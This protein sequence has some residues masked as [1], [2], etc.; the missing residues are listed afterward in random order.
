MSTSLFFF[1]VVAL[2]AT[3]TPI[4]CAETYRRCTNEEL[5][6]VPRETTAAAAAAAEYIPHQ[7]TSRGASAMYA[8]MVRVV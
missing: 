7:F 5:Q 2:L 1:S 8:I 4:A 6:R 3:F